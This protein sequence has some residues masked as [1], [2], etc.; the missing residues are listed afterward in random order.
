MPGAP[1]LDLSVRNVAMVAFEKV[2]FH[3]S[4]CLG[5]ANGGACLEESMI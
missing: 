4:K 2:C 5:A 3:Y 1:D